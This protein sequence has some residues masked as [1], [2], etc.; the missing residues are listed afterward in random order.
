MKFTDVTNCEY[1]K[2]NVRNVTLIKYT[3]VMSHYK[4]VIIF[5]KILNYGAFLCSTCII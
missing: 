5:L 3:K 1:S 4:I 2:L